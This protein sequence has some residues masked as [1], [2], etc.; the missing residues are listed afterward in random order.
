MPWVLT[1]NKLILIIQHFAIILGREYHKVKYINNGS[2]ICDTTYCR[3]VIHG[4]EFV[5]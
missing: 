2:I 3:K 4:Q 5:C 1:C